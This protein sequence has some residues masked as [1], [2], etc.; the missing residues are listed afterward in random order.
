MSSGSP[1]DPAATRRRAALSTSLRREGSGRSESLP[2]RK[3][4]TSRGSMIPRFTSTFDAAGDRP[5]RADSSRTASGSGERRIH[6]RGIAPFKP[7]PRSP[8]HFGHLL[9]AP[10]GDERA[11]DEDRGVGPDHD[12]HREGKREVVQNDPSE[13]QKRNDRDEDGHRSDDGPAEDLV[14]AQVDRLGEGL[15]LPEPD[16]L[17]DP[18][19]DDDRVGQG[20]PSYGEKRRDEKQV[21]LD[22][23]RPED[24][25]DREDVV[26]GGG[27]R[28][29]AELELEP[30]RKVEDD[31]QRGNQ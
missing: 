19:E 12:P 31:R 13:D 30:P 1:R 3:R 23:E 17:T 15:Q 24:P 25:D 7:P 16:V 4:S 11:G 5:W 29:N 26:E 28:R 22:P 2:A 21:H 20:V 8:L 27:R 6:S 9:S 10:E 14:D 18:V